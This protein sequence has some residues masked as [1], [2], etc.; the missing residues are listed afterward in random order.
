VLSLPQWLIDL[1]P[2]SHI[3]AVP[4]ADV[5]VLPIVSLV[6]VAALLFALGITGFRR[7]DIAP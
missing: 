2:F 1:S 5:T 7:R 6:V 3:P 4:A